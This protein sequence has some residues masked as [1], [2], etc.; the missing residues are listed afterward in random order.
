[1]K[2][3]FVKQ[4]LFPLSAAK[5]DLIT[6]GRES[7]LSAVSDGFRHME[8]WYWKMRTIYTIALCSAIKEKHWLFFSDKKQVV[9]RY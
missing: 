2:C 3:K 7:S 1:M 5:N 6:R 4:V 8:N 9:L